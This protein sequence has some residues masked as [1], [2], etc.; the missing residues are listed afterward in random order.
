[1][2]VA[3]S[4]SIGDVWHV[5]LWATWASIAGSLTFVYLREIMD[6]RASLLR[7]VAMLMFYGWVLYLT[8]GAEVSWHQ[9]VLLGLV[10]VWNVLLLVSNAKSSRAEVA[11]SGRKP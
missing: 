5:V 7:H 9:P 1:M 4:I 2:A 10:V 6:G 11:T 8:A 3:M